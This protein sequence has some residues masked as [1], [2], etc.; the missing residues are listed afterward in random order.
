M[1]IKNECILIKQMFFKYQV[2]TSI[3]FPEKYSE[4]EW[5]TEA[6]HEEQCVVNVSFFKAVCL[7]QETRYETYVKLLKDGVKE[8]LSAKENDA[9]LKK[10]QSSP[11]LNQE[12]QPAAAKIKR[13][14]SERKDYRPETPKVT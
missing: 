10:S 2:M 8:V 4:R 14:T 6:L 5:R 1:V 13:N 11:H 9:A 12:S 3:L 7:L